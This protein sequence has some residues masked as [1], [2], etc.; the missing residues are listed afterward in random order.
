MYYDQ[1]LDTK[2]ATIDNMIN[3]LNHLK[4]IIQKHKQENRDLLVT[5]YDQYKFC[6][7]SCEYDPLNSNDINAWDSID[8]FINE[9]NEFI[10]KSC[11][12]LDHDLRYADC[13]NS[14]NYNF[15][16]FEVIKK[17]L[18]HSS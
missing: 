13:R 2:L 15:K 17:Y 10:N 4:Y 14:M 6:I 3:F 18:K 11:L 8:Q 9:C 5:Q 7:S 1:Y 12:K 16:E